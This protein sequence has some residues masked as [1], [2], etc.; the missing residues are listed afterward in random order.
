MSVNI[1]DMIWAI[2]NFL[3]LVAILNKFLY[4][5]ILGMLDARKLDIKSRLDEANDARNE[6]MQVKEEYTREMQNARIEAQEIIT[7]A[8]KLAENSKTGI[9]QEA[10]V[11]SEKVIK[12]AQEEIRLE[13]EKAKT[14]LR[15]EVAT[16]AVLAAGRVLERTIKPED[17]EQMISQFV[18]EVGDVS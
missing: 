11:E 10:R 14:E 15:N 18:Q 1:H 4:K 7:K 13:K 12:K 8:T 16:L 17:H 6:A 5:P 3:V 2:V 9:I